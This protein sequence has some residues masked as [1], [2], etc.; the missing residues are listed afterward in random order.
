[1]CPTPGEPGELRL[2]REHGAA[3]LVENFQLQRLPPDLAL[4]FLLRCYKGE[5]YRNRYPA[6]SLVQNG[7]D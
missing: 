7:G 1:M 4:A 2:V 5:Y 6:L 3:S